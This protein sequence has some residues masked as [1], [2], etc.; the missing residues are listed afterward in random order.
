MQETIVSKPRVLRLPKNERC[1]FLRF[2]HALSM[3]DQQLVEVPLNEFSAS[4][5]QTFML[6]LVRRRG[7]HDA[8]TKE[9]L[10]SKSR[11]DK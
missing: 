10:P 4:L 6:R 7:W 1:K 2:A 9:C 8:E 11:L 3:I 5:L